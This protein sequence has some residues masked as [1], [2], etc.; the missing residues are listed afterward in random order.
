MLQG[1]KERLGTR[2]CGSNSTFMTL[3]RAV[4]FICLH[5]SLPSWS[6]VLI[7][8]ERLRWE[9]TSGDCPVQAQGHLAGS[10]TAGF[11]GPYPVGYLISPRRVPRV[12]GFSVPLWWQVLCQVAWC[13]PARRPTVD[14]PLFS[15]LRWPST[16]RLHPESGCRRRYEAEKVG[17]MY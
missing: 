7:L 17:N 15:T 11:P 10:P 6:S 8:T 4:G 5:L 16:R 2:G 14:G 9:G 3:N 13:A 1:L 12:L